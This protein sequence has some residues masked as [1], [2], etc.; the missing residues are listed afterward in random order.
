MTLY[1]KEQLG[2]VVVQYLFS[3]LQYTT[4]DTV[5]TVDTTVLVIVIRYLEDITYSMD[6]AMQHVTYYDNDGK[7]YVSAKAHDPEAWKMLPKQG[8]SR[9]SS[10]SNRVK[11]QK[12][13]I[14]RSRV[15]V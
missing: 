10:V 12:Q 14:L 15:N 6:V 11:S 5:D 1:K 9:A 2:F 7:G 4:V 13:Q 3:N 8:D